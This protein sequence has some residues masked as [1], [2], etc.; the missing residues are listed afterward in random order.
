MDSYYLCAEARLR[1]R[2]LSMS[3]VLRYF[4]SLMTDSGSTNH[5]DLPARRGS[6]C[7]VPE[8]RPRLSRRQTSELAVS[9][10]AAVSWAVSQRSARAAANRFISFRVSLFLIRRGG[11]GW[12]QREECPRGP[13]VRG[14]AVGEVP[15][16]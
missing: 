15:E 9:N 16:L 6:F 5:C 12:V 1:R 2:V 14:N 3:F 13:R 4:S 8:R 7:L 10:W 11:R